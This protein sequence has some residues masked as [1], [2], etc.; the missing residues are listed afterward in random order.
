MHAR[1]RTYMCI[2][3]YIIINISNIA[4]EHVERVEA[5]TRVSLIGDA[6]FVSCRFSFHNKKARFDFSSPPASSS[7]DLLFLFPLFLLLREGDSRF[8]R[9]SISR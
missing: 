5:H 1:A 8:S 4:R 2:Y 3:I 9:S 6:R 7:L